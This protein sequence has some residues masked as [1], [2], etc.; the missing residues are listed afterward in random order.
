MNKTAGPTPD[1]W[2]VRNN[3]GF[4]VGIWND[5]EIAESIAKRGQPSHG[6]CI[7]P[8]MI[9]FPW[10][11]LTDRRPP[12]DG[13]LVLVY[14]RDHIGA[15]EETRIWVACSYGFNDPTWVLRYE[16]THWMPLQEPPQS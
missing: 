12:D 14:G 11:L 15:P 5:R 1:A 8:M 4:W 2:A 7:L 16:I 13:K 9:A 6:E 10:I 3:E